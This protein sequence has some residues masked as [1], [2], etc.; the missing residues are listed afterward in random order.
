MMSK[1]EGMATNRDDRDHVPDTVRRILCDR[2]DDVK[3]VKDVK[4]VLREV[5][6]ASLSCHLHPDRLAGRAPSNTPPAR[7]TVDESQTAP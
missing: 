3:D 4:D 1:Q 7:Q 5:G 6:G 2:R